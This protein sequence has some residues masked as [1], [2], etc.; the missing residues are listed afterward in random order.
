[1]RLYFATSNRHKLEEARRALAQFSIDI[2]IA[3]VKKL[4]IQADDVVEISRAAAERLC[5]AYNYI[6]VEDDGL[7]IEALRGFPGPYSEYV[8][9]T[10]GLSG[11]LKLLE[12]A[13]DRSAYFKSAVSLCIDGLVKTF[14]GIAKGR[15]AEAPRGSAGFGFDPIFIPEGFDETFAEMGVEAKSKIS[16][17]AKAFQALGEWIAGVRK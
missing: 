6:V 12:G 15:I 7:Y 13:G 4:E 2:E 11:V 16:H 1:M 14:V 17:R 3:P 5:A 10:L 9:R 8:Y